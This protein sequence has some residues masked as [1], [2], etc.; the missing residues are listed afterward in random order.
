VKAEGLAH[1]LLLERAAQYIDT[2]SNRAPL[3]VCLHKEGRITGEVCGP[4]FREETPKEGNE[5]CDE[6]A[7]TI[8]SPARVERPGQVGKCAPCH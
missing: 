4:E 7:L 2:R 8:R 3:P 1:D 5:D 6:E